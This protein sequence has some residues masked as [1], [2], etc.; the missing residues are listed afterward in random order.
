MVKNIYIMIDIETLSVKSINQSIIQIGAA[1]VGGMAGFSN[2]IGS[3][4]KPMTCDFDTVQW[5]MGQSEEARQQV[6]NPE[7]KRVKLPHALHNLANFC[8]WEK[9]VLVNRLSPHPSEVGKPQPEVDLYLVGHGFDLTFIKVALEKNNRT[10]PFHYC[11]WL[12]LR[13]FEHQAKQKGYEFNI[14]DVLPK[15]NAAS[16]AKWQALWLEEYFHEEGIMYYAGN[17]KKEV[18]PA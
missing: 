14:P 7:E 18:K 11:N 1:V 9:H 10:L 17:E 2:Y 4:E 13:S 3:K 15:H 16:D 6:F 8:L 12:D 5:W